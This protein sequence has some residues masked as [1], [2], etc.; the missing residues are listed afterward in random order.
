MA[1]GI[2]MELI[3]ANHL[4]GKMERMAQM[5][6][7]DRMALMELT[8]KPQLLKSERTETGLLMEL[9]QESKQK[10]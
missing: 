5:V 3:Q 1:I 9:I 4:K 6:K 2:S 10:Q 7:T 8:V